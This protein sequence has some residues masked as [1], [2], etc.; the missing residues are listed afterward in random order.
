MGRIANKRDVLAGL[1]FV[2]IGLGALAV[3][4]GYRMGTPVR[5]GA[6]FFPVLLSGLLVF[7]G[8]VVAWGGLR[9]GEAAAP[10][11]AW[12][13]LLV[14]AGSVALFAV[15]LDRAGLVPQVLSRATVPFGPVMTARAA[16]LEARGLIEPGQR[17]EELVVVG[18]HRG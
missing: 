5:M 2:G 12:R 10:R 15:M 14:I 18:A 16:L 1:M 6:G 4:T 11:L 13:P 3:A 8:V 9:S 17:Y 7:L